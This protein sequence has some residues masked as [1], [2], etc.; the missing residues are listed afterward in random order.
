MAALAAMVPKVMI[1]ATLSRPYFCVTYSMTSPRRFMQKSMSISGMRHAL[2]I[3]EAL[4]EQLVLQRIDVGDAERVGHQR[5][6]S[7][8]AAR[9]DRNVVLF[10]VA[11]EVPHDEEVS[12]ELHLLDDVDL[13]RQALLVIRQRMLQPCPAPAARAAFQRR[14][15]PS[16]VT[17]SK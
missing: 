16:R 11:D 6:G 9:S 3:Q 12:G 13:A 10:G 5:S 15:N 17:C 1:C 4:E 14:A 7:R 2:G 8:S